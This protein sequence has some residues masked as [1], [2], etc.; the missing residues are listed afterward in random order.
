MVSGLVVD[1]SVLV[2]VLVD[3]GPEGQWA[4]AVIAG[5]ALVAPQLVVVETLNILRRLENV[6]EIT[7]LEASSAQR[8]L[9]DLPIDLLPVRPFE[10]RIWQLRRNLT[11][12]DAWYV[13]VAEALDLSFATLDRRLARATGVN[14]D[15]RTPDGARP[16]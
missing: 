8:D 5:H 15:V 1:A 13:A 9:H 10:G 14:C 3:S 2:A 6:E 7:E 11:A 4:D 16:G 12:Y